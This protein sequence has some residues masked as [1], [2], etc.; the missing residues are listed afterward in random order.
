MRYLLLLQ[1][2]Q[3]RA[4]RHKHI[5][6]DFENKGLEIEG[7]KRQRRRELYDYR[8]YVFLMKSN[9]ETMIN[10]FFIE[11]VDLM[12]FELMYSGYDES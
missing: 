12:S 10:L 8:H 2:L 11:K 9:G 5:V 4:T 1:L 3:L 7:S 6:V